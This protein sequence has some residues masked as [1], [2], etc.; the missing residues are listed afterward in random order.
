MGQGRGLRHPERFKKPRFVKRARPIY[1]ILPKC[2]RSRTKR[3]SPFVREINHSAP[4]A[5]APKRC[6]SNT[7]APL[8]CGT[9]QSSTWGKVE[10]RLAAEDER[11]PYSTPLHKQ[12]QDEKAFALGGLDDVSSEQQLVAFMICRELFPTSHPKARLE[13]LEACEVSHE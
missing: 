11:V 6:P 12:R 9:R 10:V 1:A 2:C 5:I 8:F 4:C 3:G 7:R 13:E